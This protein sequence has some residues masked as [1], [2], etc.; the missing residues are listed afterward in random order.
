MIKERKNVEYINC[1]LY[2]MFFVCFMLGL[3]FIDIVNMNLFFQKQS[4]GILIDK[5]Q[6]INQ[7]QLLERFNTNL[8]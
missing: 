5:Y 4:N 1:G 7:E 3:V 2:F 6:I 8:K